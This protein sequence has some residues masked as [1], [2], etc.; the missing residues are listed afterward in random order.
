MNGFMQQLNNKR[1]YLWALWLIA[2]LYLSRDS[3][4]STAVIGFG[5][6]Y[7]LQGVLF[8]V[9][10]LAILLKYKSDLKTLILSP[11]MFF[12]VGAFVI[13]LFPAVLKRDWQLMYFSVLFVVIYSVVVSLLID[14]KSLSRLFVLIIGSLSLSSLI[15]TYCLRFLA[16]AG[17]LVPAYLR[18]S[19]GTEMYNYF[20]SNVYIWELKWRNTGI[21]REPGVYQFFLILALYLNSDVCDWEKAMCYWGL[22]A[23]LGFTM[24]STLAFGGIAEM[25]LLAVALFFEKGWYRNRKAQLIALGGIVA[26]VIAYNVIHWLDGP[27][28]GEI[29]MLKHKFSMGGESV[30]DRFGSIAVN[31]RLFLQSPIIGDKVST[32]LFHPEILNNTSSTTIIMA[33]FGVFGALLHIGSWLVLTWKR[34]RNI[35]Y[36]LIFALILSMSFNTENL[37]TDIFLWLFPIMAVCEKVLV[38]RE[39]RP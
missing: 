25:A 20:V 35:L 29:W 5:R 3:M 10:I 26:M 8:G 37:I 16:D 13:L 36:N 38:H 39:V 34:D 9:S 31:T 4:Y 1:N 30:T 17:L 24:F 11:H 2:M 18:N 33:M 27:L 19:V 15:C 6:S 14:L 22:N 7:A 32:I 28:W 21:F 23:I 12:A